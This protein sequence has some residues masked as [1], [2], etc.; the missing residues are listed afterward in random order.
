MSCSIQYWVD[1]VHR[2]GKFEAGA[3]AGES[4]RR[5]PL[6]NVSYRVLHGWMSSSTIHHLPRCEAVSPDGHAAV[7]REPSFHYNHVNKGAAS[8]VRRY[9]DTWI[10]VQTEHIRTQVVCRRR[11][12]ARSF[13]SLASAASDI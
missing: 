6:E 5:T 1:V 3:L 7:P 9:E 8:I 2:R 13:T 4:V 11:R 10:H 12:L